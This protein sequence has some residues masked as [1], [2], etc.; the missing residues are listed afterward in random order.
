MNFQGR[1]YCGGTMEMY[2]KENLKTTRKFGAH[3]SGKEGMYIRGNSRTRS[4]MASTCL[5]TRMFCFMCGHVRLCV[6]MLVLVLV[7]VL[8]VLVLVL[9]LVLML[10]QGLIHIQRR[11]EL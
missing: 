3:S 11:A 2:S 1:E 9:V 6:P 4:C 7:L 10:V 5:G 8:V